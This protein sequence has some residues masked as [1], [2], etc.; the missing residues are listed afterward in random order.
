ML[1]GLSTPVGMDLPSR[2]NAEVKISASDF[3][4]LSFLL[5]GTQGSL[6]DGPIAMKLSDLVPF[7][8]V[9]YNV[10]ANESSQC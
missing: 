7:W 10:G 9:M 3:N 8:Q 4:A 5:A 6:D 2:I 1:L